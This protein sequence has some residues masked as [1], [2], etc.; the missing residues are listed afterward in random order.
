MVHEVVA[1]QVEGIALGS[2]CSAEFLVFCFVEQPVRWAE[3]F[4]MEFYG[5][6][7]KSA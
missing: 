2:E 4:G 6:A 1:D 7:L 5:F 3:S